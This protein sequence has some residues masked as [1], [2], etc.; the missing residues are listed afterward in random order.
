MA[1]GI[2]GIREA[3]PSESTQL[4]RKKS[5][6]RRGPT[7]QRLERFVWVVARFGPILIRKA[8]V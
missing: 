5:L 1:G 7:P 2:Q 4:A 8:A 6:L 3:R